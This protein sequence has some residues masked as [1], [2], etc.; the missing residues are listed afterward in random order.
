MAGLSTAAISLH[1]KGRAK[2]WLK[3]FG[4]RCKYKQGKFEMETIVKVLK[5]NTKKETIHVVVEPEK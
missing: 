3:L 2:L 4:H 5:V 1:R